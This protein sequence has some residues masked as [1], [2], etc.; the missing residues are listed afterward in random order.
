MKLILK[1]E[2]IP[3]RSRRRDSPHCQVILAL[4]H[5][6]CDAVELERPASLP[7]ARS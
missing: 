7:D 3:F 6:D 5:R 2:K 4:V 1:R